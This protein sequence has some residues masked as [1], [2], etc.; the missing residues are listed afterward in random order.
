MPGVI[1]VL[2]AEGENQVILPSDINEVIWGSLSF[3][4]LVLA[5]WY[6]AYRPLK[7]AIADK[8]G[9]IEE[10]LDGASEARSTAEAEL[11]EVRAQLS[12]ADNERARL[13]EEARETADGVRRDLEAK[14]ET[15]VA[16]M[17]DRARRDLA[18]SRQQAM[19]DLQAAV[20]GLTMGAAEIVVRNALDDAT[21]DELIEKYIGQVANN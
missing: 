16:E 6:F 11:E 13:L 1:T 20:G 19:A 7:Q 2:A 4:I 14:A 15:D 21:Q 10:D 3:A 17:R 18:A 8:R 5:L 9:R 12:D